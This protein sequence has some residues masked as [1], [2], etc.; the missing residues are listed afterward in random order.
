[1]DYDWKR[2][3]ITHLP[4]ICNSYFIG[5]ADHCGQDHSDRTGVPKRQTHNIFHSYPDSEHCSDLCSGNVYSYTWHCIK[6]YSAYCLQS[7]FKALSVSDYV[8]NIIAGYFSVFVCQSD[9]TVEH[10]IQS[11]TAQIDEFSSFLFT[12]TPFDKNIIENRLCVS[13]VTAVIMWH[14]QTNTWQKASQSHFRCNCLHLMV[15]SKWNRITWQIFNTRDKNYCNYEYVICSKLTV[16]VKEK[17][18]VQQSNLL[19]NSPDISL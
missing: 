1:M 11:I 14:D 5:Q 4:F 13:A 16:K 7:S 9:S 12:K 17:P 8:N 6:V 19:I 2:T 10:K 15:I 3:Q 18:S